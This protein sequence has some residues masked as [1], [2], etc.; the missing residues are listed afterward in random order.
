MRAFSPRRGFTLIE[1]LVVIAII[2][3][4]IALLLPAVQ[5]A[6]E[7]ARRSQCVNNLKQIGLALHNYESSIGSF[8][9]TEMPRPVANVSPSALAMILP[10][11]EQSALYNSCNFLATPQGFWN[12]MSYANSTVQYSTVA[13]FLC[14]SDLSRLTFA[15]GPNNYQ[16]LAGAD[17][18]NFNNATATP[19]TSM[20]VYQG[21][22]NGIGVCTKMSGIV[23][24]TSNTV[25]VSEVAK[26]IGQTNTFDPLKPGAFVSKTSAVSNDVQ[27]DYNNCKNVD[28]SINNVPGGWPFGA[29]WWWGRSSS[30]RYSHVM[31]PNGVSCGF[32]AG[33]DSN[34]EAIT[35]SSR[36]SGG[37]NSLMMDGS[38]RF[39]KDSISPSI[40]WGLATK[41][42][43]EVLSSDSY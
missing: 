4:L 8:P 30:T 20:V 21:V 19:P 33:T 40:W 37:V 5:A 29:A 31:P 3:V 13:A 39:M 12:G 43:G 36:H 16:F 23:D 27:T 26:G 22:F 42:G 6:R 1:L 9:T 15:Y 34:V 25:G 11:M 14:P 35:A 24:G 38:V 10:N 41:A 2:A 7:A 18:N 28:R 32:N 17:G